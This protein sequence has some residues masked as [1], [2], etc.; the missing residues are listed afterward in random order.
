M[1][2]WKRLEA[3]CRAVGINSKQSNWD[4]LQ[5][6]AISKSTTGIR[7]PLDLFFKSKDNQILF[8][9]ILH[10]AYGLGS[11]CV[12][13]VASNLCTSLLMAEEDIQRRLAGRN[14]AWQIISGLRARY[15]KISAL[16]YEGEPLEEFFENSSDE[17]FYTTTAVLAFIASCYDEREGVLQIVDDLARQ[18]QQTINALPVVLSH[19]PEHYAN[20]K[21]IEAFFQRR[22]SLLDLVKGNL[23]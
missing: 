7:Q 15:D 1:E 2:G 3:L 13:S 9:A 12:K 6:L 11:D 21:E 17:H 5:G 22:K 18:C 19:Y 23:S 20:I 14:V 16:G 4:V 8:K 10:V